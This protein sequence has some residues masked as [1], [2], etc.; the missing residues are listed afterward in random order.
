[1]SNPIAW[2]CRDAE[3]DADDDWTEI[4]GPSV[5]TAEEAACQFAIECDHMSAGYCC[6]R[7]VAVKRAGDT[8]QE[9]YE[10]EMELQPSYTASWV[11]TIPEEQA[12][13]IRDRTRREEWPAQRLDDAAR[14]TEEP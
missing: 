14:I 4:G 11:P 2:L 7:F 9:V 8:T 6:T 10:V 3:T 5:D 12:D 13:R 1:M